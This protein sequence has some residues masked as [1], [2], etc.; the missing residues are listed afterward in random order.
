MKRLV[1]PK[2]GRKIFGV[3]Q[4]FSKYFDVDVTFVR[5]IFILLGLPGGAPGIL[6]Y[7]ICWVVIP[8]E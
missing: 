7:I 8:E 2:K 6:L 3:C 4:A 1:R 5:L